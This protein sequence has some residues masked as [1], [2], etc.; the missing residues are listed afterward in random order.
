MPT[1]EELRARQKEHARQLESVLFVKANE[2]AARWSVDVDTVLTIPREDLPFIEYG[3]SKSRR[4]DPRD[5]EAYEQR[6]K[7]GN[8]A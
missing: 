2:L 6:A 8:A 7:Q 4:Y 3:K 5:V 1:I